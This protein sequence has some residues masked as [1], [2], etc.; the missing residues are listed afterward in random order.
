MRT[1]TEVRATAEGKAAE[2]VG[3][4][5]RAVRAEAVTHDRAW[6]RWLANRMGVASQSV[7]DTYRKLELGQVPH[8]TLAV[9]VAYCDAVRLELS[10][11]LPE[12]EEVGR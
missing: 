12:K 11:T 4:V 5:L 10:V 9:L 7:Y 6:R 8:V 2:I 1:P 3:Y